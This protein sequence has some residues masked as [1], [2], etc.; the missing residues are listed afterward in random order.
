MARANE[1]KTQIAN[2][3]LAMWRKVSYQPSTTN[4]GNCKFSFDF[5]EETERGECRLLQGL[6]F[7][8]LKHG[9]CKEHSSF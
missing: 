1:E 5:D 8:V 2:K 4:C 3:T 6:F 9:V 7:P